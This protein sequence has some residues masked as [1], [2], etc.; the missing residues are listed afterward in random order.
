MID[1]EKY[2]SNSKKQKNK[3]KIEP[4][5]TGKVVER[6]KGLGRKIAE[7]FTGDDARSVGAFVLFDVIIPAAK[8]MIVDATSQGVE[9]MFFGEVRRTTSSTIQRPGY[10]SYNRVSP[11][12]RAGAPDGPTIS[13]RSRAT[14]DFR[15]I[16]LESRAEAEGVLDALRDLIEQYDVATVADFY[17]LVG[18]TG[19]Y[20][21]DK[22]GWANLRD[23]RVIQI[24]DGYLIELPSPRTID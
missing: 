23:A 8:K 7:T 14:H 16:V 13:R 6:K 17:D 19:S 1:E 20:T 4:I 21:D 10:V 3:P 11:T 5:I 24:R 15:E 9:R 22:Y 12:G 18:I 2:P